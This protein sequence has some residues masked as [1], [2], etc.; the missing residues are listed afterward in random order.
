MADIFS[1]HQRSAIMSRVK[2]R[3][4]KATELMLITIFRSAGI[5]GWRRRSTIFGKPDFVF[6]IQ[7]LA[8]FVDGCFWHACPLHGSVPLSNRPFW[9]NKLQKNIARD[10]FVRRKLRRGGW[11]VLR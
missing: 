6:P 9:K 1:R 11:R 3:E 4:N 7:R 10:K 8:V 2:G 5:T